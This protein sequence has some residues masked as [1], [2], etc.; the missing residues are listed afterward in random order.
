MQSSG[1]IRR[2]DDLGRIVIPREYRKSLGIDLGDPM[3]ITALT[4]GEIVLKK[5]DTNGELVK[6]ARK[7]FGSLNDD[8][9]TYLVT[10][11]E[12]WLWGKGERKAEFVGNPVSKWVKAAVK[13]RTYLIG[14]DNAYEK[15][16]ADAM[17]KAV[18]APTVN[19]GDCFGAVCV[20]SDSALTQEQT[21]LALTLT[22][23]LAEFTNKY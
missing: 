6:N 10:D 4:G 17:T 19:G 8:G 22:K 14:D 16:N 13:E 5:V 3:E 1:I 23:I 12:A 18:F 7:I 11:G 20:L 2:I 9:L 21:E 15:L